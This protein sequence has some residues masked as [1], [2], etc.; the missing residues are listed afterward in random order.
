MCEHMEFFEKNKKIVGGIA[1]GVI[2]AGIAFLFGLQ[3]GSVGVGQSISSPIFSKSE[4]VQPMNVD[5]DPLWKAWSVL[6][7][8][9]VPTSS[10]T[11]L[12]TDDM[13][14]GAIQGLADSAGDPYTVFMPPEDAEVFEDDISGNFEG[15]GMEIG[16]RSG[17]LTIITPLKGTPAELAGV[18]SGDAILKID[19]TIIDG[20]TIDKAVKLIRGER[21]TIV[22]LTVAREGEDELLEIEI[23]RDVIE[24]PTISSELRDDGIFV[25]ELYNFSAT[26]PHL[27]RKELREFTLSGSDKLILDLRGNPGGYLEASVDMASWFLPAGEVVVREDFGK[28]GKPQ[29]YRSKGY[30]IFTDQLKMVVLINR[31]SASASEILAGAL[32]QHD[33]ATLVGDR[34]FGK[35]SV[36]ELVKITPETSLKVTIAR[37]LT[38]DGTSISD[39]G[40]EPDFEV[41]ITNEDFEE[42]KD[43]QLDKAVEILLGQ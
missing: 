12:S 37:W 11:S 21:G 29:V 14:W 7:E 18:R 4:A 19:D 40:L 26:S 42:G 10:S 8:K 30:D 27:F 25:I 31:G 22:T 6:N 32:S 16:M 13:L 38:P 33:I 35:G 17:I 28:D 36:Q 34:S 39:G 24:I 15:V 23:T 9:F 1:G 2:V 3:I 41:E 43:P 5:F 20:I